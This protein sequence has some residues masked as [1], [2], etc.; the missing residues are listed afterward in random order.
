MK[1]DFVST[2][3]G[4]MKIHGYHIDEDGHITVRKRISFD[5]TENWKTYK[6]NKLKETIIYILVAILIFIMGTEIGILKHR[7]KLYETKLDEIDSM[8]HREINET[9]QTYENLLKECK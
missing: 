1:K 8:Y 9:I 6:P 5:G 3:D 7:I 4:I 2:N